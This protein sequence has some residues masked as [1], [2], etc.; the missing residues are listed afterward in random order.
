[1]H[2][3]VSQLRQVLRRLVRAPLFSIITVITLA[4]G[5]AANSVI[6]SVLDG[7]LLKPLPYPQ[8]ER[9][10]SVW[11][12]APGVN[13]PKCPLAPSDYFVFREQ[14]QT[15]ESFGIYDHDS[16]SV[17]GIGAPEQ[18]RALDFTDGVLETLGVSPLLGRTLTAADI[19]ESAPATAI[20]SYGYW[21]RKFS[22][23]PSIVGKMIV[24]DGKPRE[25]IGV[26]PQSF[27]FLDEP[28]PQIILP[29]RFDRAKTHLGDFS[30]P[31]VARLK[32]GV[33]L[34]EASADVAHM[35]PIVL[36]SF[37]APD[38][39]SF[40]IFVDARFGPNLRPL[41]NDVVG[42][43]GKALWV[44]MGSLGLVLLI[45]CAN[46]ANLLLV[47]VEGRR[48]ELAIR[49]ALGASWRRLA[50]ELL[51][52]SVILGML[53][54][55]LALGL[56][57][58]AIRILVAIAPEGLPRLREIGINMPVVLFTLG[59]SMFAGL[60]SGA[61]PVLK[62]SGARLNTG[63]REGGRALSQS[64][65]QHR[66]RNT[67]VVVQVALALVLLICSGLMIRTFRALT[68]VNPGFAAPDQLQTFRIMIPTADVAEPVS[69]I[70]MQ[71]EITQKLAAIP[72]VSSVSFGTSIPMDGTNS[73][74]PV[75]EK[76]RAY[77]EGEIPPLRR[78]E[79]VAPGYFSTMGIPLLAGRDYNWSDVYN[80][81]LI[82][83]ISENMARELWHDPVNAL[84]KQIRVATT[85]DWREIVGV[86]A[87]VHDQGVSADASKTVYWPIFMDK[88]EGDATRVARFVA[89]TVRSPR[90]GSQGFMNEIRQAVWSMDSNL[91]LATVQTA[92]DFY[93]KSLARPS[94]IL[95]M[96]GVAGSM[97]LLLGIVGIYGV[98]AYSIL[99]R[100]REIGIRIAL[101]AQQPSITGMFVGHGLMLAGIGAACGL[102][103]ASAL[104][105][106]MSSLLYH[107]SP[108]DPVTFCLVPVGVLA[109]AFLASYL[110]SRRAARVDPIEA[111]R[112]E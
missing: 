21:R 79:N 38:G 107:L 29:Q 50:G 80:K 78:F 54:C 85:D 14:N 2:T 89:F 95:V 24:A 55:L 81:P 70:R 35:L 76:D 26:L 7:V 58:G 5:I 15:M 84:G 96:L 102:L 109:T 74:D 69:V 45:A 37:P 16:V 53:G 56:A 30:F 9:L 103:A 91:P 39:F 65:Q 111:L 66:T 106:L 90:A 88:F 47:R 61:I 64:R 27:H 17:T 105:R 32:P 1:M 43:V 60:L 20:L 34:Q 77:A 99:Q 87:D 40:K 8:A 19:P 86:V 63:L 36:R 104:T 49:A 41:K 92:G 82:A 62:Y 6:F 57:Y 108:V 12:T 3:F 25:I 68:H 4:G 98:I 101:G 42:D 48:Q 100:R 33:T 11:L 23:D 44:L 112:A 67:L 22:G 93:R 10:I 75:F 71:Q 73:M 18:V 46:V 72:G 52:E 83:I 97:A 13:F 28:D 94:F 51:F 31:G 110:P 59:V